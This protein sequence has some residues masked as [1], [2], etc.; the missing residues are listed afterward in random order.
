M[1]EINCNIIKDILPLYIDDVVSD[2]TKEMVEEHLEC[3]E[4][5]KKECELLKQEVY[6]PVENEASLIKNLKKKW[7]NRK[8]IILGLSILLIGIILLGTF[9]SI[10]NKEVVQDLSE[11][12]EIYEED[13]II[14][15]Y[16]TNY[17]GVSQYGSYH[18][19]PI[20]NSF[21]LILDTEKNVLNAKFIF[22]AKQYKSS[23]DG[24]IE[25]KVDLEQEKLLFIQVDEFKGYRDFEK[26]ELLENE[27]LLFSK[28]IQ[29]QMVGTIEALRKN[30]M[31]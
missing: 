23:T 8:L 25:F 22:P 31:L 16:G 6:I 21:E 12:G 19:I 18:K 10:F 1:K 13:D 17:Q 24:K 11:R 30:G 5:C 3:C 27:I 15:Y 28:A 20:T 7:R 14:Y 4:E 29:K 2:D 26:L 9:S